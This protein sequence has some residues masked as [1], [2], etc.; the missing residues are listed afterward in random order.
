MNPAD[1]VYYFN[2]ELDVRIC[3]KNGYTTMR[4]AWVSYT[5]TLSFTRCVDDG[6]IK[7]G[8]IL[9]HYGY[10]SAQ[11]RL[12]EIMKK[13]DIWNIPFR[14]NSYRVA[15]KRNPVQRFISAVTYLDKEKQIIKTVKSYIDLSKISLH[16]IDTIIDGLEQGTIKDEHFWSQT[17]FMGKVSDYNKVYDI[18][19][20][21]DLLQ[22]LDDKCDMK[23]PVSDL[24]RNKTKGSSKR[25]V[26]TKEQEERVIKLYAKDYA[27]GWC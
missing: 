14:K 11:A 13:Q 12:P 3:L 25:V 4:T 17:Y 22:Y 5:D 24:W 7:N 15:I 2:E 18:T 27:N 23:V 26:L 1:N 10:G 6:I 19:E 20:L 21:G 9:C 16:D 8:K